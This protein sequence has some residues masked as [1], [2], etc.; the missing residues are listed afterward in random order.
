MRL[1]CYNE[2]CCDE[3]GFDDV[4]NHPDA[5]VI[6]LDDNCDIHSLID[7]IPCARFMYLQNFDFGVKTLLTDL[8][9]LF[10]MSNFKE[11]YWALID[12]QFIDVID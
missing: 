6:E 11:V 3:N 10:P 5:I 1:L 7:C 4:I 2:N 9:E 12:N 8:E